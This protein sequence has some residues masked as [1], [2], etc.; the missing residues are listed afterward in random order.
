M[1]SI[2]FKEWSLV[3]DV[4]GGGRQSVI[5]RKGGMAEERG[6]F[7]FGIASSF[8]FRRSSMSKSRKCGLQGLIFQRRAAQSQFGGMQEWSGHSGLIHSQ[9]RK[10]WLRCTSS[11]PR[12]CG[13][14]L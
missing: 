13:N 2:G 10:L 9:S 12:W 3:C 8:C 5:L 1:E 11:R 7:H 14:V 6:G 4:L